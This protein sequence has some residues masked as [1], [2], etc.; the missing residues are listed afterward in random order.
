MRS[1]GT[2]AVASPPQR[3]HPLG[4]TRRLDQ[5]EGA[6]AHA[7]LPPAAASTASTILTYPVH[8]HRFPASASRT[9]CALGDAFTSSSAIADRIIPGVQ[10]PHC[11]APC[12][13]NIS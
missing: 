9:S 7:A 12:V 4:D 3:R 5:L 2:S 1:I 10:N 8:R 11:A 13:A 6:E